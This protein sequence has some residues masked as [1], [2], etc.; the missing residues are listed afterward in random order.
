MFLSSLAATIGL[1]IGIP[2]GVAIGAGALAV[3]AV[4]RARASRERTS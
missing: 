4:R 2:A 3:R 1:A